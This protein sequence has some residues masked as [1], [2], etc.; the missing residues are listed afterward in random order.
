M[1]DVGSSEGLPVPFYSVRA[2]LDVQG[3]DL[4]LL[5]ARTIAV[6]GV[7]LDGSQECRER[8]RDALSG[9]ERT[10]A[11]RFVRDEDRQRYI[12][13]HG[14]LRVVLGCYLKVEPDAVMFQLGLAGKPVLCEKSHGRD[15]SFNLSHAHG[16]ALIAVAKGQEVGV[17]LE[18]IRS[19]VEVAKLSERYFA[20]SE[21]ARIMESRGEQRAALFFRYWVAKEA[22]LKAQGVGL[23]ALSQCEVLLGADGVGAEVRVPAGSPLQEGG[24]IRLLSCGK[25][26]EAAVAAEGMDWVAQCGVL[27]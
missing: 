17:D 10:R 11:D 27:R 24:R 26:W 2:I 14:S 16:R 7:T 5:D 13:A 6:W 4:C 23:Q 18:R 20:P 12:F 1:A 9:E 15:I 21:H 22:V 19:D 8:C 3:E 25:G